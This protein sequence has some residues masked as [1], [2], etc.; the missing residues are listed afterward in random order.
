MALTFSTK[1]VMTIKARE[2]GGTGIISIG[3]VTAK[4]TSPQNAATQINKILDIV[5]QAVVADTNMSRIYTE[6]V[7][8]DG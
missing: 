2:Y 8:D 5:G 4:A 7:V 1:P 6:G 3:G